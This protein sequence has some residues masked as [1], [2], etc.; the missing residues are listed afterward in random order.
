MRKQRQGV[1]YSDKFRDVVLRAYPDNEKVKELLDSNAYFLG[2][3]LDDGCCGTGRM[4][5][6][7]EE[8]IVTKGL[9]TQNEFFDRLFEQAN[10]E[11][12]RLLA[13]K[14]WGE[15]WFEDED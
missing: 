10:K 1:V 15:E 9:G 4:S 8:V 13:Y 7:I 2:R 12:L 6:S 14:M 3:Y 11:K 5:V